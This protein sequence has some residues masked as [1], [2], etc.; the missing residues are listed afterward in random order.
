[1][2]MNASMPCFATAIALLAACTTPT[3]E[4]ANPAARAGAEIAGAATTPLSDLNLV[5]API[6]PVLLDALRA[7]YA[8]PADA[9][10]KAL[11][12]QVEALDAALGADLDAPASSADPGLVERS[13][14][15]I[16]S[17]TVDSVRAGAESVVPFRRW[18]RRLTGAERYSREV[19]AAIAAGT[20]RRS[21][22]KGIGQAQGCAAPASPVAASSR[23]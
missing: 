13:A 16:G 17:A 3:V 14:E 23:R 8:P 2:P 20:V 6:P 21:F 15:L 5:H 18:V 19:A 22:L 7:P 1:M 12:A 10:C 9:A 4:P 11:S